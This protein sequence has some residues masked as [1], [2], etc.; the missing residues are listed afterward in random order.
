MN[1]EID[2]DDLIEVEVDMIQRGISNNLAYICI[3]I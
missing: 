1:C 3:P 2:Y